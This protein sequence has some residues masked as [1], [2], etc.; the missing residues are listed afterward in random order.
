MKKLLCVLMCLCLCGCGTKRGSF[1]DGNKNM[2][3]VFEII[4]DKIM[5]GKFHMGLLVDTW[6]RKAQVEKAYHLDMTRIQECYVKGSAIESQLSEIAFF[7]VSKK[8]ESYIKKAIAF[9]LSSLK[10]VWATHIKDADSIIAACKQGRIGQY[11]YMVLG[12]DSKK[13]VNYITSMK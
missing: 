3:M 8:N 4:N 1:Q 12:E 7:K 10:T 13:V 6:W 2:D 5:E 9:R 11:Y